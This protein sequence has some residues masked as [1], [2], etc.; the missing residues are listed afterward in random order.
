MLSECCISRQCNASG[1]CS[2]LAA[3][4]ARVMACAVCTALALV[5]LVCCYLRMCIQRKLL[6]AVTAS[7]RLKTG[8][9]DVQVMPAGLS[10]DFVS[11]QGLSMYPAA[12]LHSVRPCMLRLQYLHCRGLQIELP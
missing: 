7:K 10:N 6:G 11:L 5:L 2:A 12:L 1:V 9:T 3:P 4:V 8:S